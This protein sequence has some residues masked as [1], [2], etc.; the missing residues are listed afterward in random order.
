MLNKNQTSRHAL[1]IPGLGRLSQ[2]DSLAS[3]PRLSV[4][5]RLAPVVNKNKVDNIWGM[6]H[7]RLSFVLYT[8]ICAVAHAHTHVYIHIVLCPL[9]VH[10]CSCTR[11]HTCI[12]IHCPLSSTSAYV[13]LHTCTHTYVYIHCHLPSTCAYVQLHTCTHAC[14]YTHTCKGLFELCGGKIYTT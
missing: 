10:M 12:Y 13:Y 6:A 5:S 9:H 3:Y 11:T 14:V 1:P 4:S 8:F 2:A 7:P